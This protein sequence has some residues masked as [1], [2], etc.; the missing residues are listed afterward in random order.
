M[1]CKRKLVIVVAFVLVMCAFGMYRY[2]SQGIHV[3]DAL[4]KANFIT[5][6]NHSL[7]EDFIPRFNEL[8]PCGVVQIIPKFARSP[9]RVLV[10]PAQ[11][12]KLPQFWKSGDGTS[13]INTL[14]KQLNACR[15][16][17]VEGMPIFYLAWETP[18]KPD[19]VIF[20]I[21]DKIST[22]SK[23]EPFHFHIFPTTVK[24]WYCGIGNIREVSFLPKGTRGRL[25]TSENTPEEYFP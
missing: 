18:Q 17:V 5:E 24:G 10:L 14:M 25:I 12:C 20:Q 1:N 16:I 19:I 21:D 6:N 8:E 7:M 13:I 4:R 23:V 9:H 11:T 2:S 3:D 15:V 22:F